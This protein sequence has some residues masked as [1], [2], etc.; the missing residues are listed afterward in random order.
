MFDKFQKENIEV[1]VSGIPTWICLGRSFC[2][3][4]A[5]LMGFRINYL[6]RAN[7][8]TQIENDLHSLDY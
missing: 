3:I 2:D 6:I 1:L 8:V 5:N 4:L 7:F